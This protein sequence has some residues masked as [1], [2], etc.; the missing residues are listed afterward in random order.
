M[1]NCGTLSCMHC[2]QLQTEAIHN[3]KP[4]N[5]FSPSLPVSFPGV[6]TAQGMLSQRSAL[7][8][9]KACDPWLLPLTPR[10]PWM[11]WEVAYLGRRLVHQVFWIE[12]RMKLASPKWSVN[13]TLPTHP[14]TTMILKDLVK[15]VPIRRVKKQPLIGE[16]PFCSHQKAEFH[17]GFFGRQP[18]MRDISDCFWLLGI[19][20]S[21]YMMYT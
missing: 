9:K 13:H 18:L 16:I 6:P 12:P 2:L 10:T 4:M 15:R 1:T 21:I 20:L 5:G 11:R 8:W 3:R 7:N 17:V 14:K 19:W